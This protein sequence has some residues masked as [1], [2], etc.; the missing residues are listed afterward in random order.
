MTEVMREKEKETFFSAIEILRCPCLHLTT[1][2]GKKKCRWHIRWAYIAQF[3]GQALN[4]IYECPEVIDDFEM[5][6]LI[7][8]KIILYGIEVK[9]GGIFNM[10][11]YDTAL[12]S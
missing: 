12:P 4:Q 9:T 2:E 6:S 8:T 3:H 5:L 10:K 1:A 7:K 11:I